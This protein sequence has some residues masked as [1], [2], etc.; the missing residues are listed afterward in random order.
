MA[1]GVFIVIFAAL[2]IFLVLGITIPLY[3]KENEASRGI[4]NHD[5]FTKFVYR[6]R[7]SASDIIAQLLW[8]GETDA[9]YCDYDPSRGVMIFSDYTFSDEFYFYVYEYGD[10][11][12][13]RL[14][15]VSSFNLDPYISHK[16]NPFMVDKLQAEIVPFSQ[17]G[18]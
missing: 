3:K 18:F 12:I 1:A 16:L 5:H 13:V 7:G 10:Y 14:E 4:V 17:Y 11:S 15:A 2:F 6:V 9:L 8:R